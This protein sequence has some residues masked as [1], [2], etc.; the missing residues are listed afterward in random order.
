[1]GLLSDPKFHGAA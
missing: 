1:V